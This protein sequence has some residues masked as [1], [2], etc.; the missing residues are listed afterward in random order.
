MRIYQ[1]RNFPRRKQW[2]PFNKNEVQADFE[3]RMPPSVFDRVLDKVGPDHEA[4]GRKDAPAVRLHNG[5][6]D[7][8][9]KTEIIAGYYNAFQRGLS[10]SG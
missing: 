1:I 8:W 4:C 5:F 10:R 7:G 3:R 2:P 9:G 6:I